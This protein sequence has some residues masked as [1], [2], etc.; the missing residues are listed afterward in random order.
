MEKGVAATTLDV[1]TRAGCSEG[2]L[3]KRWKTKEA[4]FRAAMECGNV[5]GGLLASMP[6]RVGRG[7][8]RDELVDFSLEAIAHLRKIVPLIM[9]SW[10]HRSPEGTGASEPPVPL[11]VLRT[12]TGYFEAEMRLGRVRRT[13]PEVVA[14]TV[15]GA[16]WHYA[17]L[18]VMFADQGMLP[19]P[20]ETFVRGFVDLLLGGLEPAKP[21]GNS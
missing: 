17:M 20:A 4:L 14:R 6:D 12:L 10:S 13:D 9:M 8:V 5:D 18:E 19:L 2:S 3:F 21:R 11:R 7:S 1:A 16:L 15:M